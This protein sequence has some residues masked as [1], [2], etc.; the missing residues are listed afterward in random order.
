MNALAI[1]I[2]SFYTLLFLPLLPISVLAILAMGLGLCSLSPLF[3]LI[4]TIMLRHQLRDI[5]T[6][7]APVRGYRLWTGIAAGIAL[8]TAIELPTAITRLGLEMA[9]SSSRAVST[10][11]VRLLRRYGS[12]EFLLRAC[13]QR[14]G[15]MTDL[16]SLIIALGK[17]V[18][19]DD[20]RKIYHRVTG[21]PFNSV[22]PP[23]LVGTRR[24]WDF[25]FDSDQGGEI[26]GGG[27]KDLSLVSSRLDGSLEAEAALAY[28]EW[29]LVFRN[30][31]AWQREARAQIALPTGG[32]VS[33]LTLWVNGEEREAAFAGRGKVREAYQEVVS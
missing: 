1:G 13:Y 7:E 5:I 21:R 15:V 12:E 24:D 2:A 29:T 17:P 28:V 18:Q 4:A 20:A 27:V 32:V 10:R 6:K 31:S 11:G 30:D 33:R 19:P 16:V 8:L 25:D 14:S 9:N 22:P 3:A 23:K 26:V